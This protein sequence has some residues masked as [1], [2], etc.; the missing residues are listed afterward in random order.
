MFIYSPVNEHLN[1][2]HLGL[3]WIM[4]LWTFMFKFL[5]QHVFNCWFNFIAL[6][7]YF[8]ET[9]KIFSKVA[10]P[11]YI[12]TS[13]IWEYQFLFILASTFFFLFNITI[14]I[15]I[16]CDLIVVLICISLITNHVEFFMCLLAICISSLEKC[17]SISWWTL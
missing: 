10:T 1:P 15:G 11:F 5:C 9:A 2:S 14:L 6:L 7:F 8:K 3:L 13:N 17:L 12:L 4:L 16:E